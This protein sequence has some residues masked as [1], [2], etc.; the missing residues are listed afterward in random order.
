MGGK[1]VNG[2][3][4]PVEFGNA[5]GENSNERLAERVGL[6]GGAGG[7]ERR[8]EVAGCG[9]G[10]FGIVEGDEGVE[11]REAADAAIQGIGR[12]PVGEDT[13]R[14]NG[15]KG[16]E[17][18][19]EDAASLENT[20][21]AFL[22]PGQSPLRRKR[23]QRTQGDGDSQGG[24]IGETVGDGIVGDGGEAGNGEEEEE[25]PKDAEG[26]GRHAAA[27]SDGEEKEHGYQNGVQKSGDNG[28]VGARIKEGEMD[29]EQGEGEVMGEDLWKAGKPGCDGNM[30][31]K[32]AVVADEGG[33]GHCGGK[34]EKMRFG[35]DQAERH[36]SAEDEQVDGNEE[37][38]KGDERGLDEKGGGGEEKREGGEEEADCGAPVFGS[39]FPMGKRRGSCSLLPAG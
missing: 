39:G 6:E 1:I 14:E 38:G 18:N 31:K 22:L 26:G 37:E 21:R 29:G 34:E 32:V 16:T 15:K 10:G 11:R 4:R 9:D 35:E 19:E 27:Q 3:Q 2:G 30:V 24:D 13:Q 25:E 33:Q 36:G 28:E 17:G 5:S 8:L 23:P 20:R 7:I 12:T